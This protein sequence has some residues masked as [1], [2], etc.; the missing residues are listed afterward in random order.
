MNL[1]IILAKQM[2]LIMRTH[3]HHQTEERNYVKSLFTIQTHKSKVENEADDFSNKRNTQEPKTIAVSGRSPLG[4]NQQRH[5]RRNLKN[6]I[7][8]HTNQIASIGRR[9]GVR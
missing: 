9:W 1:F 6:L 4:T 8:Q 2:H 5:Y 3:S 7:C